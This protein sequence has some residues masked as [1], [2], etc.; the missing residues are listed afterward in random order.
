MVELLS[1]WIGLKQRDKTIE[2]LYEHW[3]LGQAAAKKGPRWS[4]VRDV[5]H[6]VD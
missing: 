5:L 6:W 4:I 1:T 2:R 3:I